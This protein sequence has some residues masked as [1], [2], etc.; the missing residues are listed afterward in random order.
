MSRAGDM[1]ESFVDLPEGT[2]ML[3]VDSPNIEDRI[4][5]MIDEILAGKTDP[6][7][8]KLASEVL[9]GVPPRDWRGEAIAIFNFV[10]DNVRY[11]RDPHERELFQRPI[12]SLEFGTGDCDDLTILLGSMLQTVGFP[13]IITVV[14]IASDDFEHVY[15]RTG[16]PPDNPVE[17]MA[18]D[19]SRPE[20]AGWEVPENTVRVRQ[21]YFVE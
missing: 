20:P 12:R 16:L 17:W 14:G 5:H 11:T 6:R 7:I 2:R 13:V 18:L 10:R 4:D 21:D 9:Q 8:R 3:S 1:I 19:A 15:L